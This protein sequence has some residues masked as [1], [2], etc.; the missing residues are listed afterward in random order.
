MLETD[1]LIQLNNDLRTITVPAAVQHLGV[2]GEDNV[3]RLYFCMPRKYGE[4]DLADFT[5]KINF[6][7]HQQ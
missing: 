5:I 6:V 7:N 4:T 2:F 3:H 1:K